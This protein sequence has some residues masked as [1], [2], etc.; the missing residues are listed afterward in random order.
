MEGN[1]AGVVFVVIVLIMVGIGFTLMLNPPTVKSFSLPPVPSKGVKHYQ[2]ITIYADANGWDYNH[3][4]VNPTLYIANNTVVTFTVIEEDGE[5]HTLTI[6]PGSSETSYQDTLLSTAQITTIPGHVSTTKAYFDSIGV[7]TYWC[8]VHPETMVGLIYVNAT[9]NVT[10][11]TAHYANYSNQTLNLL[12]NNL[13]ANG[14]L[15]PTIALPS[16]T[17]LN[18]TIKDTTS[19]TYV[20]RISSGS[21]VDTSNYSTI[22]N[23][24]NKTSKV[25]IPFNQT[26][27]YVYWNSNNTSRFG[28][29]Y[30]YT[31]L[32]NTSLYADFN[33]WNYSQSSGV[34]PTISIS[35]GTLVN[36][37]LIDEDN[38]T[39][40]LEINP[41]SSENSSTSISVASVS[42]TV[43]TSQGYY[44]FMSTG[45]YTYW[46]LYH[47]STAVG[48]VNVTNSSSSA[49]ISY[50]PSS[51]SDPGNYISLLG[52]QT[53]DEH[54]Q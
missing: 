41:G 44:L 29:I 5:P 19:S 49:S 4:T 7:Y 36:F 24:T 23:V 20:L 2:N 21:K 54:N 33:G 37:T 45:N 47:P 16:S 31:S 52:I 40:A 30:I 35:Q 13:T 3:G 53:R 10:V 18:L 12:K 25:S 50:T 27:Q 42:P 28:T 8:T 22:I 6:N 17:L 46:D 34:N 43:K 11:P 39:H 9:V 15:Y 51:V 38:L 48:I 1:K 26:G 32:V 14:V